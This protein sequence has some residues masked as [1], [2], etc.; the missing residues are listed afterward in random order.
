MGCALLRQKAIS[1]AWETE[2]YEKRGNQTAV[3]AKFMSGKLM[4][5]IKKTEKTGAGSR[6]QTR[7][8]PPP[9]SQYGLFLSVVNQIVGNIGVEAHRPVNRCKWRPEKWKRPGI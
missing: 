4:P 1:P 9:V 6:R 2:K 8:G 5:R 3:S 7:L